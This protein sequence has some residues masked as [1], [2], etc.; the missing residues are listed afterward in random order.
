MQDER[1]LPGA[2]GAEQRHALARVQMEVD[3]IEGLGAVGIAVAEALDGDD[4]GR[5]PH[6]ARR[7][8]K[9]AATAAA[10]NPTSAA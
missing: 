7:M 3:S 1:G 4:A 5:I 2:V 9:H 8:V 6:A 10:R